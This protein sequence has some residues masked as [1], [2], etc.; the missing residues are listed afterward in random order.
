MK[1]R[2]VVLG[3]GTGMST[4]LRG[5][6]QFPLE[7]T[8]VVSVSDDGKSTGRLREEFNIPAVGDIR[9][10][11][12]ALSEVEPLVEGL[13][14]Y[15]FDTKSD[16]GGHAVGNLI[17]TAM[18][19]ISGTMSD[20]IE[21]LG[22]ILNLKGKVLP[23]TEDNVTLMGIME[24]NSIVT[25]EH[26]ITESPLKVKD[27][28]Y[29]RDPIVNIEVINEIQKADLIILSMGSIYTS[30]IP[31]LLVKEVIEA[32][33]NSNAK[34]MYVCN[35]MTQPGETD[36]Y[37]ASDHVEVLNQHLGK[38]KI[39]IIIINTGEISKELITKYKREEEKEPVKAD[40]VKLNKQKVRIIEDD[41]VLLDSNVIR[42]N[43]MK[44]SF[45][46][47]SSLI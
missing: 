17:L 24:D 33:D 5:L 32:I 21:A 16:L 12:V 6:K 28:Y 8:A 29:K 19:N 47:F 40:I 44:V 2:V 46:I 34:I 7:L 30:I 42:H 23:L 38:R 45:H 15:R 3:G 25:G 22:K 36:D 31:N 39:D 14:N 26:N 10:V 1:K 20:G 18:K 37:K 13:L 41:F 27:V 35:L 4:L 43:A 9:Q 11:L